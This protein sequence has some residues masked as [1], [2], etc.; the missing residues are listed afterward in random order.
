MHYLNFFPALFQLLTLSCYCLLPLFLIP[1]SAI[2]LL[3]LLPFNF[4]GS[5]ENFSYQNNVTW[6]HWNWTNVAFGRGSSRSK[7][8]LQWLSPGAATAVLLCV[9]IISYE[10]AKHYTWKQACICCDVFWYLVLTMYSNRIKHYRNT[11]IGVNF[12]LLFLF[13]W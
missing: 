10:N 5:R 4:L 3:Y 9:S 7:N 12:E 11:Q 1:Q 13:F 2:V 8:N 6:G